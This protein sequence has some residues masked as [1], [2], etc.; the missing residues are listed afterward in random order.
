MISVSEGGA[1]STAGLCGFGKTEGQLFSTWPPLLLNWC[2]TS[3][4]LIPR[5]RPER[6]TRVPNMKTVR[7][8]HLKRTNR[9][10]LRIYAERQLSLPSK[11]VD[12]EPEC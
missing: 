7:N 2:P 10:Q 4:V 11:I 5:D 8:P 3:P 9:E 6:L 1:E 12:G